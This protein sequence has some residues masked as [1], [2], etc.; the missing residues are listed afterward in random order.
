MTQA[1]PGTLAAARPG[2]QRIVIDPDRSE[3]PTFE[4]R[5]FGDVGQYEKLR[6]T[7]YAEL[8]PADPRNAVITDIEL[9]P[10]NERGMVEYST[11]IFILKPVNLDLGNRR[12]LL[13][14]NNRGGMRVGLLNSA[15]AINNPTT[16]AD[17]GT[18]FVMEL[19]Y[20]VVGNG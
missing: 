7:A 19:G 5:S 20:S 6:G 16:A 13:D 2:I 12:V 4:G 3:S 9:A 18:G 14:F 11:D 15:R 8:D 17:G 1:Q 10:V